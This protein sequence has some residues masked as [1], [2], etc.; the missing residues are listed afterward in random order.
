MT[1]IYEVLENGVV[2]NRVVADE[3]FMS[4]N[5][6]E[7]RLAED[8]L[9]F[10]AFQVREKRNA[11]LKSVVDQ[12]AS[13]NL[14]WAEMTVEQQ[15]AWADYRRALLDVPQQAGFPENVIWP[16]APNEVTA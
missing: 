15:Q 8:G 1:Y 7:Y 6:S 5:F 10:L 11:L 16:T 4:S 14:R 13:N 12:M 9:S 2:I 3:N